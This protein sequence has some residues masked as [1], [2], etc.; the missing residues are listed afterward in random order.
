MSSLDVNQALDKIPTANH[1]VIILASGLSQRLGQAKQLLNKTAT[2]LISYMTMLALTT[3]P[4]AIIV[5]I[6]DN[7]SMIDSVMSELSV[8]HPVIRTV[9]N[10]TP[11]TGMANSL[12]LALRLCLILLTH[13]LI[14]Y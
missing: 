10:P 13:R 3:K 6:P 12:Y 9:M 14:E 8:Q 5:V 4:Q 11:E 2:P 7:N 1:A